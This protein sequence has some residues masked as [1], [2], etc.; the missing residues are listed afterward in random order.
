MGFESDIKTEVQTKSIKASEINVA[1]LA[2]IS[3]GTVTMKVP[4]EL[5]STLQVNG[6]AVFNNTVNLGGTVIN[7]TN[8]MNI[9][10]TAYIGGSAV[11]TGYLTV[12]G[13]L[14]VHDP[15]NRTNSIDEIPLR[16]E[17]AD[18]KVTI[19]YT[20]SVNQITFYTNSGNGF[21]ESYGIQANLADNIG[22]HSF[23]V[24]NSDSYTTFLVPSDGGI[25]IVPISGTP[26]LSEGVMWYDANDHVMKYRDNTGVKTFVGSA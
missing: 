14:D 21:G 26:T 6:S 9:P 3:N 13:T 20:L 17:G 19:R 16:V 5:D 24:T 11:G 15:S 8:P 7:N 12:Y 18:N 22:T 23:H 10:G 2:V 1:D 4:T 25:K